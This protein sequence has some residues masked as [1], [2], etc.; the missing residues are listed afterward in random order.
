MSPPSFP[1][2]C[3]VLTGKTPL[4]TPGRKFQVP[5]FLGVF[6]TAAL[7]GGMLFHLTLFPRT[8]PFLSQK[9]PLP[10]YL[11]AYKVRPRY[12]HLLK[13]LED[14]SS[15]LFSPEIPPVNKHSKPAG[16]CPFFP[17][18][19]CPIPSRGNRTPLCYSPG[20]GHSHMCG[21]GVRRKI[22]SM[23]ATS[24]IFPFEYFPCRK[25]PP[26]P[27]RLLQLEDLLPTRSLRPLESPPPNFS[28]ESF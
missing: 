9:C 20:G 13:D 5:Q 11:K 24:S 25:R 15:L 22:L 14:F 19:S 7:P 18:V 4:C 17:E 16:Q 27:G 2:L 8:V 1:S 26:V 10:C 21:V 6:V 12:A 28:L 23:T 3:V